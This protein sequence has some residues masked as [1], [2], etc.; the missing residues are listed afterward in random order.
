LTVEISI[1]FIGC[2][3]WYPVVTF[4]YK[5]GTKTITFA[6]IEEAF[7]SDLSSLTAPKRGSTKL[8]SLFYIAFLF[9]F[10]YNKTKMGKDD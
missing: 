10:L 7:G 3:C 6:E 8:L 5:E 9:F 1:V 2:V 4:N